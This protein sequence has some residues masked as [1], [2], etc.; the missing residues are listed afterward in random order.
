MKVTKKQGFI[1]SLEKIF[2]ENQKERGVKLS[3]NK[4]VRFSVR[5]TFRAVSC[6]GI[7]S[8]MYKIARAI[9][10]FKREAKQLCNNYRP[11]SRRSNISNTIEKL[12]HIIFNQ[13]LESRNC[14]YPLQFGFH[15]R[16]LKNN[17]LMSI[18][19]NIQALLGN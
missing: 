16:F 18:V 3:Q 4:S 11:I 6:F 14:F 5:C 17:A 7:F 1:F 10:V 2:L 19:K 9:Q 15:L 12:M 13:F 8:N